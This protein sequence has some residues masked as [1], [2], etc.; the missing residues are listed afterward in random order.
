[1]H[2]EFVKEKNLIEKTQEEFDVELIKCIIKTKQD[3][4]DSDRKSVV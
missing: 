2:E 4:R 1:M 3:L